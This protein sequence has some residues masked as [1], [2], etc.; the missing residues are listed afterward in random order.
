MQESPRVASTISNEITNAGFATANTTSHIVRSAQ[1][2]MA[3][4]SFIKTLALIKFP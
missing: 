1:S 2:A 3:S 4:M